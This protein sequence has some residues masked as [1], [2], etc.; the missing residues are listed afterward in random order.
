MSISRIFDISKRS[1]FSHQAAIDTTAKNISN[2]NTEGYKRRQVDLSKLGI[3]FSGI[4]GTQSSKAITRIRQRFAEVQLYQENHELGK[5]TSKQTLLTRVEDIYGEPR[6]SALSSTLSQFWNSWDELANDPENN[7]ARSRVKDKGQLLA[8]TFNSLYN[9]MTEFQRQIGMDV[10]DKVAEVNRLTRQ[11]YK[12]NQQIGSSAT[13]DLL[14][15]RDV[16]VGKLSSLI[17]VDVREKSGQT[18]TISTNGN[19]LVSASVQSNIEVNIQ[20]RGSDYSIESKL[21][22]T[23]KALT[24]RSG[25]LGGLL[26]TVN[27]I[28]PS[29]IDQVNNMA[30]TIA[31]NVNSLHQSGYDL[32]DNSGFDFFK[33]GITNAGDFVLNDSIINDP[34]LIVTSD[35]IGE[36]GN[37]TIAQ[38]ISN[39]RNM[40]L[41][42]N[43]SVS[44]YYNSMIS[45]VGNSVQ[46]VTFLKRSQEKVVQSLRNQRD[47]VSAVSLDEE[48][49]KLI[50]YQRGY[51]AATK[52]IV[53]A[54]EMVQILL[55]LI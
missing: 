24:I 32:N 15:E 14:D 31:K 30:M 18:V 34:T 5:Y 40:S 37:G 21:T 52:M 4:N 2:V 44:D 41:I 26:E 49:T 11:I 27:E 36:T 47:S 38:N 7:A 28:I 35:A 53:T 13:N 16:L 19:I 29:Q 20:N 3:G 22:D 8:H 39:L 25:E 55:N 45:H 33:S 42:D 12:I 43:Q 9:D 6:E 48:M 23:G 10:Q 46:E 17:D 51:Q 54:N 50:E 1:L